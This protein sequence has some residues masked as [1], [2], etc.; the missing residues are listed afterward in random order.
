MPQIQRTC[1]VQVQNEDYIGHLVNL[2]RGEVIASSWNALLT[3]PVEVLDQTSHEDLYLDAKN[4]ITIYD[5][6]TQYDYIDIGGSQSDNEI[7][8]SIEVNTKDK[9]DFQVL[10][11]L[12]ESYIQ[13]VAVTTEP[14]AS[15]R[16]ELRL[17]LKLNNSNNLSDERSKTYRRVFDVIM[18][19]TYLL[20]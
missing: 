16:T 8:M 12:L 2:L 9:K 5:R 19:V 1:I 15:G 14:I 13:D 17:R 10:R 3:I 18:R 6:N 7:N 20:S 11:R 4:F